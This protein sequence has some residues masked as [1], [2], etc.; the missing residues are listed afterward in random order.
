M[1]SRHGHFEGDGSVLMVIVIVSVVMIWG[2][3]GKECGRDVIRP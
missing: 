3:N 1:F 2:S